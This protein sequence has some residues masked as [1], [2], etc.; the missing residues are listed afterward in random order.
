MK[1]ALTLT[2]SLFC[3][4]LLLSGMFTTF[5]IALGLVC[6][7][8][9]ARIALRMDVVDHEGH[10]THLRPVRVVRYWAWLSIEIIKSS[11]NVARLILDP[12]MPIS[13]TLIEV[14]S[15][16]SDRL[17]QVI[18]ANSIT[19]TP[20]TVS[21]NLGEKDIRVHALTQ[22]AAQ[23]LRRGD[24]DRRVSALEETV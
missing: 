21:I 16:Q 3:L 1:H 13:P 7:A 4:W 19:L 11:V 18:Y 6:C 2:L 10:P 5:L 23:A 8:W 24:M 14:E 9:V 22:E 15:T 12:K 20:G 17:G